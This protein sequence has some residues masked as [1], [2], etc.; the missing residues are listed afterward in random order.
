MASGFSFL[1]LAATVADFLYLPRCWNDS[2][3]IGLE[4]RGTLPVAMASSPAGLLLENVAVDSVVHMVATEVEEVAE[5]A[6]EA[7]IVALEEEGVVLVEQ[8]VAE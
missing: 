1:L 7:T 6:V 4:S 5:V 8:V 2:V 3:S